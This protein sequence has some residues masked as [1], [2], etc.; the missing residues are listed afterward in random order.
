M[1]ARA[2]AVFCSLAL[3]SASG[4]QPLAAPVKRWG[5]SGRCL[6]LRVCDRNPIGL[7]AII[8]QRKQDE[9][10]DADDQGENQKTRIG[11]PAPGGVAAEGT[12]LQ[13]ERDQASAPLTQFLIGTDV[14]LD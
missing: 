11:M 2:I 3:M 4:R 6:V 1:G 5:G 12:T 9:Q 13:F 10:K 14:R 8:E 7:V